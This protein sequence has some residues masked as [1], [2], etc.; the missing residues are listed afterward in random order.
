[1]GT[2]QTATVPAQERP[3]VHGRLHDQ[4]CSGASHVTR[5]GSMRGWI[6]IICTLALSRRTARP[7]PPDTPVPDRA[8]PLNPGLED[9]ARTQ[10]FRRLPGGADAS[11]STGEQHIAGKQRQNSR[12]LGDQAWHAEDEVG[13][14]RVLHRLPSTAHPSARSAG[15][16]TSPSVTSQGPIGP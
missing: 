1:M 2:S 16:D 9:L 8:D 10:K 12:E 3:V 15:S 4:S 5:P 13:G 14:A 7:S 11:R 6:R